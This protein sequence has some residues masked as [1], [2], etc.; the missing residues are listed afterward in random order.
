MTHDSNLHSSMY[1]RNLKSILFFLCLFAPAW[2]KAEPELL[3]MSKQAESLFF[4]QLYSDAIPVY[5]QLLTLTNEEQLKSQFTL[6][7]ATCH[8]KMQQSSQALALLTALTPPF[9]AHRFYLMSLAYR[10]LN[11]STRA[12]DLLQRCSSLSHSSYEPFILLEKGY[13]FIQMGDLSNARLV[14]KKIPWEVCNG[15]PYYLAQLNLAKIDLMNHQ[16]DSAL[17]TLFLLSHHLPQ[18]HTL[19]Q[20]VTYLKG[21]AWLAKEK[22]SEAS[23]CFET[24]L[25]KALETKEEWSLQILKGLIMSYLKQAIV[26][27]LSTDQLEIILS[28]A[29]KVLQQLSVRSSIETSYLLLSDFYLIKARRLSDS[30]SYAKA[31]R[32]LE[33]QDL[34]SSVEEQRQALIKCAGAA[35]TFQERQQFYEQLILQTSLP[36]NFLAKV[37]L[38]KGINHFEEGLNYQK[39]QAL[40]AMNDQFEQAAEACSQAFQLASSVDLNQS[41]L[42]LKHQTLA[43]ALQQPSKALKAWE[44]ISSLI[45]DSRL[46][47]SFEDPR[48]VYCLAAWIALHFKDKVIL[49]QA[50]VL[51]QQGK[52]NAKSLINWTE[53]CLK[54]EGLICLQLEEWLQADTIFS[55]LLQDYPSFYPGEMWFWRAYSADKQQH[56]ELKKEY[57]KQVYTQDP[58]SSYAPLAY[59]HLYSYQEYMQGQRKPL[60]HLQTMP[61]LFPHHPLLIHA[62]YLIGLY[63]KKDLLSEEGKLLRRRDWTAAIEAFQS[64][65]STFDELMGKNLISLAELS[66]YAHIRYR[67]ELER[68]QA[69]LAIAQSSTGGKKQI[70]LKYA[71]G[72][73]KHLIEEFASSHSLAVKTLINSLSSYPKVW[74]EAEFKLAQTYE[75]KQCWEEAEVILN[76]ALEHYRQARITQNPGLMHVWYEKGKLAQRQADDQSALQCFIEA[77]KATHDYQGLTPHE[78]LDLWIQQSFCYKALNQLDH[79]MRLLSRVI[80]DDVISPLRIKAMF[81]RAEIYELQGRPE[82][83][84][85]Q[86]EATARKGGEW[87][88]KAQEKLEQFYGY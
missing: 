63:H 71:E 69:N 16:A 56:I 35:P 72:V 70:Y 54:F 87:A 65:E 48:E 78:K 9:S 33:R 5:S 79:A 62:Y 32:L 37:W 4:D 46:L 29:E 82:L 75:E 58:E 38:L 52:A 45:T 74:A 8:L 49:Q 28:K 50:K 14:L 1:L 19:H 68:A 12:L 21:W 66:Y 25:H 18:Q 47:S 64:A 61:L 81:L 22:N 57:L 60:K 41:A 34:F 88:Q 7:L 53:H 42:A 13:H 27:E 85:K 84:I 11:D 23:A 26:L 10:Q 77:E 6:R 76:A 20:E 73:F 83:A 55:R 36:Q 15:T 24:L 44:T 51:L 31:C 3:K 43:Y 17:Q 2:S 39:E 80:N 40:S 67:A 30:E 59:F 86:L